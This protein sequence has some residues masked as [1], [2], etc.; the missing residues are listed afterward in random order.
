M[1]FRREQGPGPTKSKFHLAFHAYQCGTNI[2][3]WGFQSFWRCLPQWWS[4]NRLA[5]VAVQESMDGFMASALALWLEAF[6]ICRAV[7]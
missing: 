4:K 2:I 5:Q 6:F 1:R 7:L 3:A